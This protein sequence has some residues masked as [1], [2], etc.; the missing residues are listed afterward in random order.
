M[1]FSRQEYWS[2]LLFPS[3]ED[4]PNPGIETRTP[5]LQVDA[6][7]S[8]PPGK[9]KVKVIQSC[10]SLCDPMDY[11]VHG[12]LQA[13]VLEW[14]ALPL[15]RGSSQP[16]DWTQV[17]HIAGRL[18]TNWAIRE[19]W[20]KNPM[21]GGAVHWVAKSWKR[22]SDL[23]SRI[24]EGN[25]THYSVLA[26]R[27]PETGE[28]GGLPSMGSHRGGHNCNDLATAAAAAAEDWLQI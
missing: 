8:E 7:T 18:F 21:D 11:T 6:L 24:G 1:G 10:L 2:G 15:S 27:I 12:I 23:L 16:R 25:T 13:R 22:L 19:A 5:A 17:F 26:W 28:P 3:P 14:V 20:W 4:L 9:P